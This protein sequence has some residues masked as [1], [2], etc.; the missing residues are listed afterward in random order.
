MLFDV[1]KGRRREFIMPT[2]ETVSLGAGKNSERRASDEH[3]PN[4][5]KLDLDINAEGSLEREAFLP[6]TV[7]IGFFEQPIGAPHLVVVSG[8][9]QAD[10]VKHASYTEC[11]SSAYPQASEYRKDE[12][13]RDVCPSGETWVD[14]ELQ[15][16]S[17]RTKTCQ[18]CKS[19]LFLCL[20]RP[21]SNPERVHE[22]AYSLP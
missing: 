20:S 12:P 3:V 8:G 14:H 1:V 16:A 18:V 4:T 11:R 7:R 17:Y 21:M 15:R 2:E 6:V 5:Q 9:K 13:S 19:C 10:F 22:D